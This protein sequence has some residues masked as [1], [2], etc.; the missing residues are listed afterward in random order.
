[1]RPLSPPM[2]KSWARGRSEKSCST[3][4]LREDRSGM[5][6]W[7][8]VTPESDP[9]VVYVLIERNRLLVMKQHHFVHLAENV[10]L[11]YGPT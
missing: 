6:I 8:D 3:R 1:M 9:D 4:R 5:G 11:A 2:Q 10:S 7:K